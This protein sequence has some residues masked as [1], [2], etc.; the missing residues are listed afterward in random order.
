M[1]KALMI[2]LILTT[3]FFYGCDAGGA[4]TSGS[5][6]KSNQ[7]LVTTAAKTEIHGFFP[8]KPNIKYFFEGTGQDSFTVLNEYF[9]DSFIQQRENRNGKEFAVVYQVADGKIVKISRT[10]DYSY[11]LD[12]TGRGSANQELVLKEPIKTGTQWIL[13]D[14]STRS[15]T[16]TNIQITTKAGS[17][18]A[19]EVTTSG[20]YS[21]VKDYYVKDMGLVKSVIVGSRTESSYELSKIEE[22]AGVTQPIL[23]YYPVG[24]TVQYVNKTVKFLTNDKASAVIQK[25][26][27]DQPG[28]AEPVLTDKTVIKSI[29]F[30]GQ[31]VTVDL[32]ADFSAVK[33]KNN[34]A[35]ILQSL[36]NT[37][38]KY[39]KTNSVIIL[40][41][42]Q[43][44]ESGRFQKGKGE[45]FQTDYSKTQLLK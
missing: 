9:N 12:L 15:I 10:A 31:T 2:T 43:L 18:L 13:S 35:A 34:E 24:N 33:E 28:T 21:L 29:Y 5:I 3:L 17:F 6:T 42:N 37:M 11:R 39:Y 32:S 20:K 14:N 38:G 4:D 45:A 44:Y 27:L 1:K 19:V 8:F 41:D 22:N 30:D 36:V 7:S 25:A 26:Y 40:I 16:G 23:F